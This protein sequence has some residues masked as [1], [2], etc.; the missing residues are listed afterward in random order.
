[1]ISVLERISAKNI[2]AKEFD[3]IKTLFGERY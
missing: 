2:K 1:M 3:F